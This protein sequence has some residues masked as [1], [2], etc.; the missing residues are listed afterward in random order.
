MPLAGGPDA[1]TLV[2]IGGVVL[3]AAQVPAEWRQRLT[4][5]VPPWAGFAQPAVMGILNVTPDSFSDGGRH[6]DPARAIEAGIRM[7]AEGAA[8]VDV[9]GETTR[10]GSQ[11][12]DPAE[13]RRRILPVIAGLAAAGV[14][15]SAD[16]RNSETMRAALDE[17]A[18]I[19]NDVSALAH[20]PDAAGMIARAGCPVVLMHMRHNPDVMTQR[21][22]Y[23]D[24]AAEVVA[25]LAQ[26]VAAAEAAGIARANIA[27][28]PGIGFGKTAAHNL[29]LLPRLAVLRSLGCRILVGVSRKGFIGKLADAPDPM[30]RLPGSLAAG[31]HAI[32]MGATILRVHDVAASVQALRVWRGVGGIG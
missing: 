20:D 17:G 23:E 7:A 22:R 26:R 12:T 8:I 32:T 21:A 5:P 1:F 29:A 24:V 4:A 19:I 28:D 16:T 18:S 6:L 30:A 13:E 9:G 10:P 15:V 14:T 25:E 11:P 3:P 31:L 27:I 2:R